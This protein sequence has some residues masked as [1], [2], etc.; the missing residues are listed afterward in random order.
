MTAH[1]YGLINNVDSI[2][3]T[4][5]S[6]GRGVGQFEHP[7]AASACSFLNEAT[8][9]I[10]TFIAITDTGNSRIQILFQN[11]MALRNL[12]N[13]NGEGPNQ[14]DNPGGLDWGGA[15]SNDPSLV[16]ADQNN[17][18]IQV[19]V[20]KGSEHLGNESCYGKFGAV[21]KKKD[22]SRAST[23]H[24]KKKKEQKEKDL[25]AKREIGAD[26]DGQFTAEL[27][28]L[29]LNKPGGV[30]WVES[31]SGNN[32]LVVA[33]TSNNRLQFLDLDSGYIRV[34]CGREK[35]L[36]PTSVVYHNGWR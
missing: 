33:D 13:G 14:L 19:W 8:N 6:V 20:D 27:H 11:G 25:D 26:Y 24:Q 23:T 17:H 12:G 7:R 4:F 21:T 30:C 35:V 15:E 32:W 9:K 10:E 29:Q 2:I 5:G 18:R 3:H 31:G 16:V 36:A 22:I 1:E 34:L 28:Q